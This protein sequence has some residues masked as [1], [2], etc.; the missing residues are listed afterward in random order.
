LSNLQPLS[1]LAHRVIVTR[2]KLIPALYNAFLKGSL[3]EVQIIGFARRPYTDE[4]FRARL[5][6]GVKEF[7]PATFNQE[8]WQR[9]VPALRYFQ[10]NL[11]Q[12]K[13]YQDLSAYLHQIESGL[14][15]RMYYLATA[16]SFY[17]EIIA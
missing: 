17:A 13:D 8:T 3:P 2:R 14:V 15:N 12:P 5:E 10:G 16:P 9:F 7:S 11:D 1:S 6:E 4:T